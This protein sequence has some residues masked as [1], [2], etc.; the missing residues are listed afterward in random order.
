M[1]TTRQVLNVFLASPSDLKIERAAAEDIVASV[2]KLTGQCFGWQIDLHKWED[3][4]PGF[5]RPQAQINP[6]V[7][8][9]DLFVGLL[10]ERWGQPSGTHTS[11][12]E[13]EFERARERRKGQDKPE[14]WLVFK[15]VHQDKLN[16]PGDQLKKV[17]DF[18]S[19]QEALQEVMFKTVRD[20]ED[21]KSKLLGW[22]LDHVFDQVEL[23][24]PTLQQPVSASPIRESAETSSIN[25]YPSRGE[26]R[27]SKQ[28]AT[29][30]EMLGQAVRD[31][32]ME[33]SATL[34][35]PLQEFDVARLSLLSSTLISH[36]S[37]QGTL[38][39]H[40][41]NLLYKHRGELDATSSES[42]HLFRTI[43]ESS[44]D[45]KPG[46]YWLREFEKETVAD[47]LFTYASQDVSD[48]VRVGA[49]DL[50]TRA[51]IEIPEDW[52]SFL[53]LEH[54]SPGVRGGAFTYLGAMG[55]AGTLAVLEEMAVE[56][57]PIFASEIRDAKIV[58]LAASDPNGA[59]S[60]VISSDSYTP[61]SQLQL[62]SAN[63]SQV[64]DELLL[65]G[66]ESS[67][68][69]IK[70]LSLE[71]LIRR[72]SLPI[73]V[74][75]KLTKDSSLE[76]RAISFQSLAARGIL[77]D[78]KAVRDALDDP[79]RAAYGG[80]GGMLEAL[81]GSLLGGSRA[82]VHPDADS[83]IVTFLCTQSTDK[84]R[85]ELDWFSGGELAY[86]ALALDRFEDFSADL[87]FDLADGFKRLKE[88]SSLR[89]EKELGAAWG[90]IYARWEGLDEFVRSHFVEA[91]LL[92]LAKNAE[93]GD[94]ELARPYLMQTDSSLR[95]PAVAVISKVGNSDD[96]PALLKIAKEAY[97]EVIREAAL[98]ALNL[99]SNPSEVSRELML[100]GR[101][102]LVKIAYG[103][104]LN[105][106]S[107][108]V[109]AF[110]ETELVSKD[111]SNRVR[112]LSYFSKRRDSAELSMMLESYLEKETY[113]YNV[114]TW[115][116]R[117]LY[118]PSPLR[119]M[120]VR[121]LE[122]EGA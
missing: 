27:A 10:W 108:E 114:L 45:T 75:E 58:I 96:V 94:A 14:I 76:L 25:Q 9:C 52:R 17:M 12:F 69:E 90:A 63:I 78:F 98:A 72:G 48:E 92:G 116:D 87:R 44:N 34:E 89:G 70:K 31:G 39:T 111:A 83:I 26:A 16:D 68:E 51:R 42:S 88:E 49:L 81:S 120:F 61:K 82:R 71:E 109:G 62:L 11:G 47:L 99:S 91:A 22:L 110:F 100:S 74:A 55:D 36:R 84:L 13:E 65:K 103:W 112:A 93:I 33:F 107:E 50:L 19:R 66:T 2:N 102:E 21:W 37:T 115:L 35:S 53:P 54:K 5:G 20:A 118:S 64:S 80:M 8:N 24:P 46:W 32:A 60:E 15:D 30:S 59:F 56:G 1:E 23:T 119:E 41:I 97:G 104:M 40:E 73:A 43:I 6:M 85:C 121:E 18:R 86:R 29:L 67:S 77:P 95:N 38:G 57:G 4:A 101:S 122:K 106:D 79:N 113:Y 105:Q 7:D 3:T 117:L 28:L